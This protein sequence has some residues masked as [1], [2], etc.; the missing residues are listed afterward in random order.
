MWTE[1]LLLLSHVN[2]PS[3]ESILSATHMTILMVAK[4]TVKA[5]L[6]VCPGIAVADEWSYRPGI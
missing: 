1:A 4:L 5:H 3:F 6:D 2:I